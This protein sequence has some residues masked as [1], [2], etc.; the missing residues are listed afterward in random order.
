[1]PG[2][3]RR[4][5]L[6]AA[7]AVAA[8]CRAGRV[9][10]QTPGAYRPRP[11]IS[12]SSLPVFPLD[13]EA[14]TGH[15]IAA[16]LTTLMY[17]TPMIPGQDGNP[18]P[19]IVLGAMPSR[20]GMM[21]ELAVRPDALFADGTPVT[22]A[23]VA[24]S[25]NRARSLASNDAASWRFAN[26]RAAEVITRGV[27]GVALVRPD[28]TVPATL[29]TADVPIVPERWAMQS[30]GI[31]ITPGETSVAPGSGPFVLN[32]VAPDRITLARNRGY[33][34]V[35]RPHLEGVDL[36]GRQ[37][38][39]LQATE[40]V[41]G[42]IDFVID[43]P[44]LDVP[45]LLQDPGITVVGEHQNRLCYLQANLASH[46][47]A[48]QALRALVSAAIDRKT[49]VSNAIANLGT[50]AERL[51]S[52]GHW[53]AS[54][55]PGIEQ[56]PERI[57]QGLMDFGLL[58]GVPLRLIADIDDPM[59]ANTCVLLQDQ[60]AYAGFAVTMDLLSAAE[61]QRAVADGTYDLRAAVSAF[62]RDPHELMFPLVASHGPDN[63]GGFSSLEVDVLLDQAISVPYQEY[64]A[65]RYQAV[66]RV[67]TMLTPIIPLFTP[68]YVDAH[69]ATFVN[70]P[71]MVPVSALGFR[72]VMRNAV[73]DPG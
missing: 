18:G 66:Q 13:G 39:V 55:E 11:V 64:R 1:M 71:P 10:A 50:P 12:L 44:L 63:L 51:L 58:P 38:R 35:S 56:S 68:R 3:S 4:H 7:A 43:V 9:G 31:P 46:T 48:N 6:A 60:L 45:V 14:L 73:P 32:D 30:P 53:A 8:S 20:D 17:D 2:L 19:G 59:V 24:A 22:A 70:Y 36:V 37:P 21:L 23:D 40:L 34:Q 33:W 25:I 49:L 67:V 41:T 57:R 52:S 29:A 61:M 65:A 28:V 72:Q 16:W 5:L 27:V 42:D 69:A 62:W 15:Q 54:D 26:F 47:L